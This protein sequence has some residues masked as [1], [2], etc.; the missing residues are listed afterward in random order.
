MQPNY[1]LL[2]TYGLQGVDPFGMMGLG[3][4]DGGPDMEM[5]GTPSSDYES[6]QN[7]DASQFLDDFDMFRQAGPLLVNDND[8]EQIDPEEEP[9]EEEE[10]VANDIEA[11][12]PSNYYPSPNNF[13]NFMDQFDQPG[14]NFQQPGMEETGWTSVY[15]DAGNYDFADFMMSSRQGN[16]L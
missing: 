16:I 10:P 15:P 13:E 4:E 12:G 11:G 6:A 2:D 3:E 7:L 8:D 9:T 1:G 5:D 14:V